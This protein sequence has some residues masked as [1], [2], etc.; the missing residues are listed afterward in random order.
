VRESH[1]WLRLLRDS[2]DPATASLSP[3]IRESAELVAILT[4]AVKT[5]KEDDR[6]RAEK[7]K[8]QNFSLFTF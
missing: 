6:R 4:A 3:L 1:F 2:A 8:G 5:A 7:V